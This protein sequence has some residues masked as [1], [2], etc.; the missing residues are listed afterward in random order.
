MMLHLYTSQ[1]NLYY[2]FIAEKYIMKEMSYRRVNIPI[3]CTLYMMDSFHKHL[4]LHL[5]LIHIGRGIKRTTTFTSNFFT[6]SALQL[7]LIIFNK[8]AGAVT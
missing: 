6:L 5:I 2:G 4:I 3:D 1:T 7:Q 8:G